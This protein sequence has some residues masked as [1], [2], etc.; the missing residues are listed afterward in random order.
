MSRQPRF[1]AWAP[2]AWT[3]V[4]TGCGGLAV[5]RMIPQ[6]SIEPTP[7]FNVVLRVMPVTNAKVQ[8]WGG[9]AL[10]SN[11]IYREALVSTLRKSNLF[12]RIETEQPGDLELHADFVAHGQG[13]RGAVGL[14]YRSAMVVQYR[15]VET[16][17]GSELWSQGFNSRHEVAVSQAFSGAARTIEAQEGSV[18]DN[19]AQL[20]KALSAAELKL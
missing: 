4:L 5:T 2:V 12:R 13:T 17:S 3:L 18:R 20:V 11:E 16:A 6:T 8:Q 14:D 19:L 7:R 9:P 1:L 15:I 10:V